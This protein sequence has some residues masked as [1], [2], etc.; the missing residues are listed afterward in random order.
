MTN[1]HGARNYY[2]K[3]CIVDK[4]LSKYIPKHI[5][6]KFNINNIT[7]VYEMCISDMLLQSYLNK[8]R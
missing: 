6:P 5:K 1:F 3:V 2:V 8:W 7:S 4:S